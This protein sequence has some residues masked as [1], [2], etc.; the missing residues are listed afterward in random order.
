MEKL[1]HC[2]IHCYRKTTGTN[3][4]GGE[5]EEYKVV[6]EGQERGGQGAE[7]TL[8]LSHT[9]PTPTPMGAFF[10]GERDPGQEHLFW[11]LGFWSD[12]EKLTFQT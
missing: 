9:S 11:L 12:R 10:A 8:S 6:G 3:K 5:N 1:Q 7:R 4:E 2:T